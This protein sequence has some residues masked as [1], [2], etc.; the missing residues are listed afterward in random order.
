M[1]PLQ[2]QLINELQETRRIYLQMKELIKFNCP[3]SHKNASAIRNEL[4]AGLRHMERM[5]RWIAEDQADAE[6]ETYATKIK[7]LEKIGE[8][9]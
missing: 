3:L 5:Q 8:L 7:K 6:S 9:S 1:N 2:L 4:N